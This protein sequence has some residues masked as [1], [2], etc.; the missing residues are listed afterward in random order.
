M[1]IG[2]NPPLPPPPPLLPPPPIGSQPST[3]ALP[4]PLTESDVS[5]AS[6]VLPKPDEPSRIK[7]IG[8]SVGEWIISHPLIVSLVILLIV[9]LIMSLYIA[10]SKCEECEKYDLVTC[11]TRDWLPH[12]LPVG[13][14]TG[15]LYSVIRD[16]SGLRNTANPHQ[17]TL[18]ALYPDAV[19][20]NADNLTI[21]YR[22]Y[23]KI[24][25]QDGSSHRVGADEYGP[26]IESPPARTSSGGAIY[27]SMAKTGRYSNY[28]FHIELV[29]DIL[30]LNIVD[31]TNVSQ[32][33]YPAYSMDLRRVNID[34][35][36]T[37]LGV[38]FADALGQ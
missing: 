35:K 1:N 3:A 10:F 18:I 15:M 38:S 23:H 29:D 21:V 33:G 12:Y 17:L 14:Q 37:P 2:N 31:N 28:E 9:I 13:N 8:K 19:R 22:F 20:T 36:T 26:I 25:K 6:G 16:T 32:P 7:M 11:P 4:P 30:H 34:L 24:W 5:S 27:Y